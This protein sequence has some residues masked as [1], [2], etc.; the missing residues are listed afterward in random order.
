MSPSAASNFKLH[1][2]SRPESRRGSGE[3]VAVAVV[4]LN[5]VLMPAAAPSMAEAEVMAAA[6]TASG[7]ADPPADPADAAPPPQLAGSDEHV[8][9]IQRCVQYQADEL[10]MLPEVCPSASLHNPKALVLLGEAAAAMEGLSAAGV[11]RAA[12]TLLAPGAVELLD[13]RLL[14]S[15][16]ADMEPPPTCAGSVEGSGTSVPPPC[17]ELQLQ[18]SR[19][20]PA[21]SAPAVLLVSDQANRPPDTVLAAAAAAAEAAVAAVWLEVG[22]EPCLGE[23]LGWAIEALPPLLWASESTWPE[24]LA[25]LEE[26]AAA[27]QE[28][29]PESAISPGVRP[30]HV[31]YLA[32]P[33]KKDFLDR[34][35]VAMVRRQTAFAAVFR[36]FSWLKTLPL[37]LCSA[38][39]RGL[40]HCLCRCVSA[41]F[42]A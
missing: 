13:V 31:V 14:L 42:V 15:R 25:E 1:Y 36:C 26:G 17:L 2:G 24:P 7:T 20:Y 5:R 32:S 38:A 29:E 39:F 6:H 35:G 19:D 10:A 8:K 11:R 9:T 12:G 23:V 27:A 21:L 41:A 30:P 33:K 18:L 28:P 4:Q 40:R 3:S 37:P 22:R 34:V 16:P